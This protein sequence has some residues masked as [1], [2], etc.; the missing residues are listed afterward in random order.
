MNEAVLA[1]RQQTLQAAYVAHPERFVKGQPTA[2]TLPQ[3]VWINPP[4]L[5][6][7]DESAMRHQILTR[8][9]SKVLTHSGQPR[10]T[11]AP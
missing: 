3:A 6:V 11:N 4:K 2:A 10:F 7:K 5:P 8:V 1:K 9:V